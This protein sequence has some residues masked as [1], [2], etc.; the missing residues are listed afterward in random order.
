MT[1]EFSKSEDVWRALEVSDGRSPV[2]L[3]T[4]AYSMLVKPVQIFAARNKYKNGFAIYV[5]GKT[6]KYSVDGCQ[7]FHGFNLGEA[8]ER[9]KKYIERWSIT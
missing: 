9:V 7:H 5:D 2:L 6:G 3:A 4:H 1:C 8:M